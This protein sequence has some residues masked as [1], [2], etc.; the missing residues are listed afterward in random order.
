MTI[1]GDGEN[2]ATGSDDF[3]LDLGDDFLDLSFGEA[4]E[5]ADLNA[6]DVAGGTETPVIV[7]DLSGAKPATA[8][9][10]APTPTQE[11]ATPSATT[12]QPPAPA[13]PPAATQPPAPADGQ[14]PPTEQP[15]ATVQ[16]TVNIEEFVAANHDAIVDNLAKSHFAID[17]ATAEKLAFT[18][19][20]RD[21]VQ[22]RDAKNFILTM[23]HVNNALQRSLPATVANLLDVTTKSKTAQEKFFEEF[24]DLKE[25]VPTL[26]LLAPTLRAANPTLKGQ[27]FQTLLG[28]MARQ[29][30]GL[31]IP[32]AK[33]QAQQIA[34][35]NVRRGQPRPFTPAG[36][37]TPQ[38]NLQGNEV[39]TGLEFMN[40][41]LR[42]GGDD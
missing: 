30:L 4:D 7:N 12:G 37:T 33:P 3:S 11:P 28:N 6:E 18:P 34:G 27:A 19:E 13:T 42:Q 36:A 5:P 2:G 22:K 15:G 24:E 16:P 38:R 41:M 39:P 14:Q 32:Q 9:V 23:V 17:D 26:N 31:P 35:R 10:T 1:D 21:W 40:S 20:V 8:P 25:H 29:A